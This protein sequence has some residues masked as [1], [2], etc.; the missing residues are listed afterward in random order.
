MSS[1]RT[2]LAIKQ[3]GDT[4]K[5]ALEAPLLGRVIRKIPSDLRGI[6]DKALLLVGFAA[7]LRRAMQQLFKLTTRPIGASSKWSKSRDP[8]DAAAV[9]GRDCAT[10][11]LGRGSIIFRWVR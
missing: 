1:T 2:I 3:G 9:Q 7:A 5:T 4:K 10:A 6:R 11:A 8:G